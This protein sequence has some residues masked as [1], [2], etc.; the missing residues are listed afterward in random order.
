MDVSE[1]RKRILHALDDA[2]R[3]ANRREARD[4]AAQAWERFRD[5][6][7]V[8]IVRQAA[9]VL[10]AEGH[11]FSVAT[12][13]DAVRL[14][15]E[16]SPGTYLELE[17]DTSPARPRVLARVSVDRPDEGQVVEERHVAPDKPV[18]AITDDDL[19]AL[20]VTEIPKLV[21]R[22]P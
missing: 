15:S 19:A 16:G 8:P 3:D 17:L 2:R 14:Q 22:T 13:V 20:L 1:L 4:E 9:S 10:R 11:L 12:P 18:G 6:V 7:A 21:D 5:R